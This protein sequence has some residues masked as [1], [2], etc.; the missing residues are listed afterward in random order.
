[1]HGGSRKTPLDVFSEDATMPSRVTRFVPRYNFKSLTSLVMQLEVAL[2]GL[3][4]FS[5]TAANLFDPEH[6]ADV[7]E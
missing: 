7:R 3:A 2:R 6:N 5:V 4:C 1:L